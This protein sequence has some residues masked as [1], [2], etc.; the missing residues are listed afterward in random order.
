MIKSIKNTIEHEIIVNKSRFIGIVVHLQDVE[1]V[2]FYLDLYKHQYPEANHYCYAY[3]YEGAMK[4]SDDGEPA[5]TAGAPILN[6]I[7]KQGL[8]H[9]LVIVVRYFGGIK[10]GAGGLV[11][12]YSQATSQALLKAELVIYELKPLYKVSFDYSFIKLIDHYIKTMS[13][14]VLNKEYDEWVTYTCF[15]DDSHFF[16]FIQETTSNQYK[17][18]Y[19]RDEYVEKEVTHE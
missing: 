4:A 19:L 14:L 17:K 7:Q 5:K 12:A 15:I 18:Q 13:I 11:R 16:E 3:I 6:V 9:I 8:D 1:E 10:L 2:S